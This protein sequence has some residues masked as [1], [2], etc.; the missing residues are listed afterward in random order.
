MTK[1][2]QFCAER[3]R[4]LAVAIG[5]LLAAALTPLVGVAQD[6]PNRSIKVV[7]GFP[8]GGGTDAAARVISAEMAKGLG[9]PI[10]IEN[11][12]GA[13]GSLGA[14]EVARSAP[15]GYTLLVTPGGHSIYGAIFK[16]L[17]FDTV[18]SFEWVSTI[19]TIPFLVI[20][21]PNS[22]F[23]TLADLI[24]KAKSAPGTVSFGSAGPGSTHH[25]GLELLASRTGTKFLHVPYRG[26]APVI[27]ALLGSEVQFGLA[28]PTL[29]LENVKAGKLRALA[30]TTGAR[31]ASLPDLPTVAEALGITF[32]VRSWFAM[33]APAGTP[34]PIV[35]RLN[36]ELRK[37]AAVPEVHARLSRLG[38]VATNS[39]E[40]MRGRVASELQVWTKTVDDARIEKQ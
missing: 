12:P 37:A 9:Q 4:L 32:D 22:E 27:A 19:I 39:S 31:S 26:D 7:V 29:A 18:A 17:P 21:P 15:D 16:A 1:F 34:K 3:V 8:P 2:R 20:V 23:R 13:A 36:A 30:V 5:L 40:E 11:K 28:T 35:G 24:A 25:L 14:A 6:Y 33:A 10:V 38:E